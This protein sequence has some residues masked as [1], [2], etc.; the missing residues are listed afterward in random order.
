[1]KKN[2]RHY[3]WFVINIE[4]NLE[5]AEGTFPDKRKLKKQKTNVYVISCGPCPAWYHLH[6]GV[7]YQ[8]CIPSLQGKSK[9]FQPTFG[10]HSFS[11]DTLAFCECAC[12]LWVTTESHCVRKQATEREEIEKEIPGEPSSDDSSMWLCPPSLPPLKGSDNVRL[13]AYYT[14]DPHAEKPSLWRSYVMADGKVPLAS[15]QNY[16]L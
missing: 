13:V 12:N 1:M 9:C 15:S 8:P 14:W 10:L 11:Q 2:P 3:F 16:S 7:N 4:S 6:K 5:I